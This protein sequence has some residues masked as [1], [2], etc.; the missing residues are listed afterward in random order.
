MKKI[1]WYVLLIFIIVVIISLIV[2]TERKTEV[3]IKS[4]KPKNEKT[5]KLSLLN[6]IDK[7]IDYFN[8]NYLDRYI[9][10]KNSNSNLDDIDIIIRVNIGLDQP[11]YQNTKQSNKLNDITILINKY[12][13]LPEDYVPNNLTNIS[14]GFSKSTKQLVYEAKEAF[15]KMANA[16]KEQGYTIRVISAYR[17]Y[18]YQKGLYDNYVQKD[19]VKLADTYSARPGFSEHQTG[20][21][22]DIDNGK[23]DFNNFENTKEFNWMKENAHIY[24]FILRY[25]KDKENITGYDYESWHYRYVGKDIATFIKENNLTFD[26]YYI[27]YISK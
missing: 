1:F 16:A 10:Y 18:D 27:K 20:L 24:G 4:E 6:N 17:S 5:E 21:V 9:N 19:G 12:I 3:E 7:K 15:E 11:F 25:P 13:Y 23:V 14:P 22:V 26:E 8:Y 2:I